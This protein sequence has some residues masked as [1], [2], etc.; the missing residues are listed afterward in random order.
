[1]IVKANQP[2]LPEAVAAAL[3]GTDAQFAEASWTEEGQGHGRRERRSVRTAPAGGSDWP[4][5][6]QALRIRRDTGPTRG[7]WAAKEIAYGITSLPADLAGPRHLATYARQHWAVENRQ[8]YAARRHLPRGCA[9]SPNREPARQL[10]SHPQPR[11][12]RGPQGGI[13]QHSPRPPLLRARRPANS[14]T[15]RIRLNRHPEHQVT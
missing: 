12:R 2:S 1:M 6:A 13:R 10:R 8:H 7:H 4:G 15:L 3:D 14:R 11:H 9:E 5:A